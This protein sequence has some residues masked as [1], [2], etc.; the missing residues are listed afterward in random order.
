MLLQTLAQGISNYARERN[1]L[2]D[3]LHP[4][5][6]TTNVHAA[7]DGANLK[8]APAAS[9]WWHRRERKSN[10]RQPCHCVERRFFIAR[11]EIDTN[12]QEWRTLL[13][14][15]TCVAMCEAHFEHGSSLALVYSYPCQPTFSL[16]AV[17][18]APVHT[19]STRLTR[20]PVSLS[21]H[22]LIIVYISL[23]CD[24]MILH[25][26][27]SVAKGQLSHPWWSLPDS[28]GP[29]KLWVTRLKESIGEKKE[30]H[31]EKTCIEERWIKYLKKYR[32][33]KN[34]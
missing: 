23:V 14:L 26:C 4:A 8:C 2:I 20:P 25:G 18:G 11:L 1:I 22:M 13:H 28:E 12:T 27:I 30:E 6:K 10:K 33:R 32:M 16:A 15:W 5:T 7:C 9:L 3:Q 34:C 24:S 31:L 29:R 21:Y 17:S 19:T